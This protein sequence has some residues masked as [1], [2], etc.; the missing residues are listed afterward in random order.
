MH[1]IGLALALAVL[2]LSTAHAG[3]WPQFLGPT[4]DG[5]SP[6]KVA[7]WTPPPKVLWRQPVGDGHSS[8]VVSAGIVYLHARVPAKNEEEVIAFDA[9]TGTVKWRRSYP[10]A[11]FGSLFGVGP[12]ATPTV[13][14]GK[15]YALGVTGILTCFA[16]DSGKVLWQL[17]TLKEFQTPNLFFGVSAS[18]LVSDGKIFLTVGGKGASLVALDTAK[19]GVVW[20]TGD[21][22]A[23]Y[24]SPAQFGTGADRQVV[25]LTHDGLV[26]VK[27]ED[28]TV[29]WQFPFRDAL[30]ESSTTPIRAGDLLVASSV[31]QGAFGLKMTQSDGKP[32]VERLWKNDAL[33]CYFSTPVVV[34][35]DVYMVTGSASPLAKASASL[36]CVEARTGKE[37][38]LRPNV[39]HYHAT[40]L[41]TGDGKILMMEDDGDLKLFEPDPKAYR[42]LATMK[43][44]GET[45]AHPA[46]AN[47]RFYIRD[48]KELL[49]VQLGE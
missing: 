39:G 35:D 18:P 1:R 32:S 26:A 17:D 14:D 16:A 27:P 48:N 44:C 19:G 7:P 23:S 10:R 8:P 20:K 24:A 12:R 3:D 38:W 43:L 11:P 6:E 21:D 45:W 37:R 9:A 36:R 47:G 34:G 40:L 13:A 42:E 28:G 33:T 15:V 4:R 5:V 31:T 25:F 49:C 30:S 46:L 29:F 22:R 2:A 41:R